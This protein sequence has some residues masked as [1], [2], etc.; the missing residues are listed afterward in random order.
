MTRIFKI[1]NVADSRQDRCGIEWTDWGYR[2]QNLSF[3]ATLYDLGNLQV[4]S[5]HVF[6]NETQFL[7]EQLLFKQ[8]SPLTSNVFGPN[9]LGRKLLE[10][11]ELCLGR[12]GSPSYFA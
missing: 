2:E 5:F 12:T 11:N 1:G 8:E 7:D 10:E 4:Q 6:L 3:P 9:A